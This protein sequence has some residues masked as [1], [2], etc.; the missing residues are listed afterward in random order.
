[1]SRGAG[2]RR[3]LDP[4]L[5]WLSCWLAA[6]APIL[7][8]AWELPYAGGAA[9]KS[10]NRKKEEKE[11]RKEGREKDALH[12]PVILRY[13]IVVHCFDSTSYLL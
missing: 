3:G 4:E 5:L 6:A 12:L 7:P 2:R 13:L 10:K 9:L 1:M 8:L 11:G